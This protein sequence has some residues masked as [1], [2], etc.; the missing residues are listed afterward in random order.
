[1]EYRDFCGEKI[2]RLGFGLMRLPMKTVVGDDGAEVKIID[3]AQL[4]A[5]TDRA[6]ESGVNYFDTAWPYHGGNSELAIADAL[7]KYPRESYFL[8]N[9]FPGHQTAPKYDA[10]GI[11]EKQLAKCRVDYFD[12]YL[13][14]NVNEGCWD[15]YKDEKWGIVDYFVE[16]RKAGRIKHL[17]FSTHAR[18]E[19]LEEIRDY[20]AEKI[21]G[22]PEFCQIQMNYLDWT[23]QEAREKYEILEKRG[24]PVI[25]MEPIRGGK[26]AD[27]GEARNAQL[28]ALRPDESI[29]SWSF[30]W[31]QQYNNVEIILS[32]MSNMEQMEDNLKTFADER[33][34]AEAADGTHSGALSEDEAEM[35]LALAEEMK[36]SVPCTA[37][38]YCVDGCPMK[39]DI[40]MLL[41]AYNDRKFQDSFTVSIHIEALPEDRRPE[42]CIACGTC[43]KICPQRIDVP[44]HLRDFAKLMEEGVSWAKVCEERAKQL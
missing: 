1:M 22:G 10:E 37:C 15:V 31:I 41:K 32:G 5:M 12:F 23:L 11:F 7:E 42:A 2:S 8:A 14:H 38:R 16:Q 28:K 29:A 35:L 13:L 34:Y 3:Q 24:I 19:N 6:I 39:L 4:Q 33:A 21:P 20:L 44:Y 26:L 27:L 17:G 30:R 9:K 25:V 18:A 43:S 36:D 40:P